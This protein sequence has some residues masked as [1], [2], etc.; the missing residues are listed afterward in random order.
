[1]R[2]IS[3]ITI[4]MIT[5]LISCEK[6]NSDPLDL[7]K[8]RISE[9]PFQRDYFEIHDIRF[10]HIN[11]EGWITFNI[12]Y[13]LNSDVDEIR[14]LEYY[15]YNKEK[16][17]PDSNTVCHLSGK[18]IAFD[19]LVFF[20]THDK[21][22]GSTLPFRHYIPDPKINVSDTI[23][24]HVR[25]P[26]ET[27]NRPDRLDMFSHEWYGSRMWFFRQQNIREYFFGYSETIHFSQSPV[28]GCCDWFTYYHENY[29]PK[30]DY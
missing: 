25:L 20:E 16:Y 21:L 5:F 26:V 18:F 11:K 15:D 8:Y 7:G 19:H 23:N 13:Y 22:T 10:Y 14:L 4:L 17:N 24:C 1:M 3:L 30:F 28:P 29:K 9:N 12:I 27:I 6:E 2:V